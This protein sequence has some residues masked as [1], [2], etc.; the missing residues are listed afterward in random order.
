MYRNPIRSKGFRVSGTAG[1]MVEHAGTQ[2][3]IT[4]GLHRN[5]PLDRSLDYF[6]TQ[7]RTVEVREVGDVRSG[8]PV[9]GRLGKLGTLGSQHRAGSL[10]RSALSLWHGTCVDLQRNDRGR[11]S[12]HIGNVAN[13]GT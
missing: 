5:E 10:N 6:R 7:C 11:V 9:T 3:S 12:E 1:N 8:V 4:Q 13:R 2:P